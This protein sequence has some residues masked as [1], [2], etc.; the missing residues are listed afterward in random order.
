VERWFDEVIATQRVRRRLPFVI[1][2]DVAPELW[3]LVGEACRA[4]GVRPTFEMIDRHHL[5]ERLAATAEAIRGTQCGAPLRRRW[6]QQLD[7]SDT[8]IERIRGELRELWWHYLD[9]SENP[10]PRSLARFLEHHVPR[11]RQRII[12]QHLG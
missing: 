1:V 8:A 10:I 3:N 5:D 12:E 2:Q 11:A 7:R 4:R 9:L 6:A